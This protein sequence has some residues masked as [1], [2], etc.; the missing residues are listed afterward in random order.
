M[1]N[2]QSCLK[3]LTVPSGTIRKDQ[4]LSIQIEENDWKVE[5]NHQRLDM[6]IVNAAIGKLK[7]LIF[8]TETITAISNS[9]NARPIITFSAVHQ[10]TVQ[11]QIYEA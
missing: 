9:D 1:T 8:Q 11:E 10:L 2:A 5:P 4:P 3:S 7:V 6:I